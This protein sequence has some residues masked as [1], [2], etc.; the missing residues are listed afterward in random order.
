VKKPLSGQTILV[1]RPSHQ[2]GG[3]S[4]LLEELGAKSYSFPVIA[5][6]PPDDL[7][8]L[9]D[10]LSSIDEFDW[11]VLTSTNGVEAVRSRLA[12]LNIDKA[13]FCERKIAVVGPATAAELS[14]SFRDPDAMPREFVAE[15][16]ADCLGHVQGMK[17]LFPC[18]DRARKDL[19]NILRDRGAMV[20][21]AVAYRTISAESDP[22]LPNEIPNFITLTSSSSV[23]GIREVLASKGKE[24]WMRESRLACI[25]P[26]TAATVKELGF[27]VGLVA[28]DYT[29]PGL[30]SALV[31]D[32][33]R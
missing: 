12:Q 27:E 10:A 8:P 7:Q 29:I 19:P 31:E 3:L 28:K 30:V 24:H 21:E 32:C 26:I 13:R 33:A 16:I 20:T 25:G 6:A 23:Y 1:T 17:F 9:D 5:I 11:V 14:K 18:A 2:S 4:N 15:Q 22:E